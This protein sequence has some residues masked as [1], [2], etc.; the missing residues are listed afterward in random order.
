VGAAVKDAE[1]QRQHNSDE[2]VEDYPKDQHGTSS[3]MLESG[4]ETW[5]AVP[6][7]NAAK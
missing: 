1:V 4:S 2:D 3:S 7:V 6:A 5:R